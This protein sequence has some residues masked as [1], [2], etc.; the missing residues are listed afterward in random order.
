MKADAS[1]LQKETKTCNLASYTTLSPVHPEYHHLPL[2][3][4][5]REKKVDFLSHYMLAIGP[6][7]F[8]LTCKPG[9]LICKIGTIILPLGAG[10]EN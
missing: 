9:F 3:P 1:L 2:T 7:G 10:L 8:Y 4:G 5:G 6:W